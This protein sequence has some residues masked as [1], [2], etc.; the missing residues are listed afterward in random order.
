MLIMYIIPTA[1]DR[2]KS[3]NFSVISIPPHGYD[4]SVCGVSRIF[5]EQLLKVFIRSYTVCYFY[6]CYMSKKD[7]DLW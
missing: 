6:L 1:T 7:N 3:F 2:I 5:T 4:T